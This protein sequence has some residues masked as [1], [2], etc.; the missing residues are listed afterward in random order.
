MKPLTKIALICG[1][2]YLLPSNLIIT[3]LICYSLYKT[4]YNDIHYHKIMENL[5]LIN[6]AL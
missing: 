3:P 6:K 2:F 1:G 4:Y 5:D